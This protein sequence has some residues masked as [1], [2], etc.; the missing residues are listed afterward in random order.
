MAIQTQPKDVQVHI[1]PYSFLAEIQVLSGN[2]VQNYNK[3]TNDYEPDRSLVPCV[4]M[5]YVSVSDPE[6]IMN[7]SQAIT[8]AEWYEG[9]PKADSSNRITGDSNYVISASGKPAYSLTV[10]KNINPSTPLELYC[11][12]SFTDKRKNTS[13]KVER[14]VILRSSLFDSLAYS[15]KINRPKGWT[16]NPLDVVPNSKGE[17]LYS[18]NAQLYSAENPVADA[19]TAYWWQVLDGT[20]WRDFTADELEVFVSGKNA[21]GTWGKTLTFD[22]RFIRNMVVRVRAAY[23]EGNRPSAPASENL[24]ATTAIK[25]E[26]PGTLRADIRQTKG[27]KLSA[28]M[29]TPVAFECL[30]SYN[31]QAIPTSKDYL[32]VIEWY[33]KSTKPGSTAV[34]VG[35]GRTVEFTPSSF[36]FNPLYSLSVYAKVKMY[37]VTCLITSSTGAVLTSGDALLI[38]NKYE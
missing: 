17:W 19:N 25:V 20:T 7:G 15:V 38:T 5:P 30:L 8:G 2:P 34:A 9:A 18:I 11:I 35:R 31:K 37:A 3:D 6:G 29:T 33:A 28:R 26:M 21:D 12:F 32:F 36:S 10:K 13:E 4:L 14:S 27:V 16:I 23:Y 1:D 24:Q 22:A